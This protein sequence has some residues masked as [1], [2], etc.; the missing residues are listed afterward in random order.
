M[1]PFYVHTDI[2][3][4]CCG[5]FI[6]PCDRITYVNELGKESSLGSQFERLQSVGGCLCWGNRGLIEHHGGRSMWRR[7]LTTWQAGSGSEEASCALGPF[8]LFP[9]PPFQALAH[10][11]GLPTHKLSHCTFS[12]FALRTSD[13]AE[14]ERTISAPQTL[15]HL[16]ISQILPSPVKVTRH[17]VRV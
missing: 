1:P 16:L 8:S 2:V 15:R 17:T 14:D 9:S 10:W 3:P 4:L 11:V 6:C 5:S 13:I 12:E 7:L